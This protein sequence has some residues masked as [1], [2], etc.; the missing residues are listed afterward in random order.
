MKW[1]H[2][3]PLS[4]LRDKTSL[5]HWSILCAH[6]VDFSLPSPKKKKSYTIPNFTLVILF[7]FIWSYKYIHV[8][9]DKIPFSFSWFSLHIHGIVCLYCAIC[10]CHSTLFWDSSMST[11]VVVFH[12]SPFYEYSLIYFTIYY[13]YTLKLFPSGAILEHCSYEYFCTFTW[14]YTRFH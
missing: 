7:I 12:S 1:T 6:T 2:I 3:Y 8:S 4:T 5:Y 13:R 11:H 10:M 14:T 9:Q